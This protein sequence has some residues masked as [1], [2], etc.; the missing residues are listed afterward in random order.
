MK[1]EKNFFYIMEQMQGLIY[2]DI[3]ASVGNECLETKENLD[4]VKVVC[5]LANLPQ[6]VCLEK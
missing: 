1:L 2:G 4:M 6:R 3:L 5:K